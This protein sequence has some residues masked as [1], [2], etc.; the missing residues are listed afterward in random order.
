MRWWLRMIKLQSGLVGASWGCQGWLLSESMK[1]HPKS[2]CY[3]GTEEICQSQNHLWSLTKTEVSGYLRHPYITQYLRISN[4]K[5]KKHTLGNTPSPALSEYK[6][7]NLS[8]KSSSSQIPPNLARTFCRASGSC[9]R[10]KARAAKR[11]WPL[12]WISW[13]GV[14]K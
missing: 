11:I 4:K 14:L 5:G 10:S 1:S 2:S 13:F 6:I 3:V 12:A 7:S 8:T 9:K